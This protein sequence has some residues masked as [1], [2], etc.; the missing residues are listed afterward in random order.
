MHCLWVAVA[1]QMT[2][3][4]LHGYIERRA[5]VAMWVGMDCLLA[6]VMDVE[7]YG[8]HRERN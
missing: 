4:A 1:K 2:E 5:G 3:I 7:G 6:F 8:T